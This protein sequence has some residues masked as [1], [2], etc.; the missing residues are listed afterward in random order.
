MRPTTVE[1]SYESP[2]MLATITTYDKMSLMKQRKMARAAFE[3][4]LKAKRRTFVPGIKVDYVFGSMIRGRRSM[5]HTFKTL[6]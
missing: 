3:N 2:Y 6:G 5:T 1:I 4:M